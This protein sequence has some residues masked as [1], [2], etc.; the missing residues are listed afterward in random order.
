VYGDFFEF[1]DG[2]LVNV[3]KV[4]DEA[5]LSVE[6]EVEAFLQQFGLGGLATRPEERTVDAV[7]KRMMRFQGPKLFTKDGE[8]FTS[9]KAVARIKQAV[10]DD[11]VEEEDVDD[12]V[13]QG[14]DPRT[15]DI[16]KMLEKVLAMLIKISN[17]NTNSSFTNFTTVISIAAGLVKDN[18]VHQV[19]RHV[20]IARVH[21]LAQSSLGVRT[22]DADDGLQGASSYGKVTPA[23]S[24]SHA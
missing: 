9:E 21:R 10:L 22:G 14:D 5:V 4:K 2:A 11:E 15:G 3:P 18:E 1:A 7:L 24:T 13:I 23:L 6:A 12:A 19:H 20:Y 16:A 17:S 8:S